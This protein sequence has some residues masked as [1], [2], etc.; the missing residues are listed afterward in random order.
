MKSLKKKSIVKILMS[1]VSPIDLNFFAN[2]ID[3]Y[4]NNSHLIKDEEYVKAGVCSVNDIDIFI[5]KYINRGIIYSIKNKFRKSKAEKNLILSDYLQDS[6]VLFPRVYGILEKTGGLWG[7][8]IYLITEGINDISSEYYYRNFIFADKQNLLHYI[9]KST[10][11][12]SLLHEKNVFHGDCKRSNFYITGRPEDFQMGILDFDG[13][14]VYKKIPTAKRVADLGRFA[15][16]I[17]EYQ[18]IHSVKLVKLNELLDVISENYFFNQSNLKGRILRRVKY[19]MKRK[20][21]LL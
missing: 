5:K 6:E 3:L 20:N 14:K 2:E 17:L 16:A 19:H 7:D 8:E 4:L 12:L 11:L 18:V 10:N 9:V 21:I 15:A 1:S 13:T